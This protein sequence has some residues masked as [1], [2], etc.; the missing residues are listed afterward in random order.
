[1]GK[2]IKNKRYSQQNNGNFTVV[3]IVVMAILLGTGTIWALN[4]GNNPGSGSA[5]TSQSGGQSTASLESEVKSLTDQ[6]AKNPKD[7]ALQENL[8]T[9]LF[10]LANA[11]RD[12][13]N[14]KAAE[15]FNKTIQVYNG[16][17]QLDPNSKETLGDLATAYF[18]S[19]QTDMAITT[20]QK[21][22]AIDPAFAPALMN[23]GIYLAYGKGD[24]AGAIA[25]LQKVPSGAPQYSQAQSLIQDFKQS[26]SSNSPQNK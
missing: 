3:I 5:S 8:G 20:V 17:L 10:N 2:K 15:T 24:Y 22:L 11:Y 1:M 12:S 4:S 21:A 23:Y 14:P 16:A 13:N 19:N 6:V 7:A 26:G 25:Q 9:A 18:Y